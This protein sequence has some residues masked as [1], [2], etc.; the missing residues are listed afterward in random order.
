MS[1]AACGSC[2]T[3]GSVKIKNQDVTPKG[4]QYGEGQN[5]GRRGVR[6]HD[7]DPGD[8]H[9][10]GGQVRAPG[11]PHGAGARGL[12]ALH[13]RAAAQSR[14]P[15]LAQPRPL[16][17]LERARLGPALQ[18][19]APVRVRPAAG[20][21]QALQTVGQPDPG[22]PGIP[23]HGRGGDHDRPAGPGHRQ[24][25]RHGHRR[26]APGGA[27]QPRGAEDRGPLHLCLLRRR[28]PHGGRVFGGGLAG[29]APRPGA[30]DLPLRRQPHHHRRRHRAVVHGGRGEALHGLRLAGPEGQG[31]ERPRGHP[32]GVHGRP[33]RDGQTL[34]HRLPHPHRLSAAR[35]NRTR[36]R[37]TVRRWARTRC[38]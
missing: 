13:A 9:G 3:S 18:P 32:A 29:R 38:G 35:T 25:R 20:R 33:G 37:P 36:T 4:G 19:A 27:L 6:Q 11:R 17:A 12:R 28:R 31:R 1:R 14:Q 24:R 10:R 30:A 26:A 21:A 5:D 8:G 15:R 34:A 16:R 22:A 23:A 7:P 2:P